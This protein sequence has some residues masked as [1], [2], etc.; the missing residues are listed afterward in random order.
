MTT[1]GGPLIP[2]GET[3]AR[4]LYK[5]RAHRGAY[6]KGVKARRFGKLLS[7]NPY[8]DVRGRRGRITYSRGFGMAWRNGWFDVQDDRAC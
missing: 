4:E 7:E 5:N 1:V 6:V 2:L 3:R 8:E